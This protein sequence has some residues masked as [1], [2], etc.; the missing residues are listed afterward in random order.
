MV[1]YII[2][3]CLFVLLQ[4]MISGEAQGHS[5][6]RYMNRMD[7]KFIPAKSSPTVSKNPEEIVL[8]ATKRSF[9]ILI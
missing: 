1:S 5:Y 3:E 8:R 4:Y 2:V 7:V 6:E 9:F